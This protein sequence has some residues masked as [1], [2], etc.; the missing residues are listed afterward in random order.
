MAAGKPKVVVLLDV[1]RWW[2]VAA[3]LVNCWAAQACDT[4]VCQ[5]TLEHWR[6]DP[7][8]VYYFYQEAEDPDDAQVNQYLE[9]VTAGSDTGANL[10]FQRVD[11]STLGSVS[12]GEDQGLTIASPEWVWKRHTSQELPLHVVAD[13]KG[14]DLFAGRLSLSDAQAMVSSPKRAELARLLCRGKQGVL[15]ILRGHE[16]AENAPEIQTAR[17]VVEEAAQQQFDVGLVEVARDDPQET[18]FVRQLLH[19]EDDLQDINGTMV[20]GVFGRGHVLEPYLGKGITEENLS[21]LVAF[22]NGPC[23]CEIKEGSAGVDLLTSWN[24]NE[25]V[26]ESPEADEKPL[27]SLLAGIED[28]ADAQAATD[29]EKVEVAEQP[30]APTDRLPLNGQPATGEP[31]K[32]EPASD[33]KTETESRKETA[34]VSLPA[35]PE[36]LMP[37]PVRS[38]EAEA[39]QPVS[40]ADSCELSAQTQA[41]E[42]RSFASVW[43]LRLGLGL[44]AGLILVVAVGFVLINRA[45]QS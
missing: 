6:R 39:R 35:E 10:A 14:L 3:M 40:Q 30:G 28:T 15:L 33:A 34:A 42:A 25:H 43:S 32:P 37:A 19:V 29:V 17:Q 20:F 7:Y 4:P 16:V 23:S 21:E 9:Q 8:R 2:A 27:N 41:Q 26:V 13:P 5:Y 12:P 38:P 18:W 45:R 44:I 31:A 36:D 11:V 24:W 1:R 22:M